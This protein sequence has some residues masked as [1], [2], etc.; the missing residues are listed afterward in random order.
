MEFIIYKK[1]MLKYIFKLEH[2]TASHISFRI[3]GI[4]INCLKTSILI[5]RK[6]IAK[7]YQSFKNA[8]D[9]P[10]ATGDL[11]LV[12][13]AYC[14]FLKQFDEI[15]HKNNIQYW[16]DFGTLIGAIR[17]KGFIP[18]DDDIDVSMPRRDYE[19]FIEKFQNG[20]EN[21]PDLKIEFE[22][23]KKNK[24]F[25]KLKDNNS[26]NLSL[27]IFPYDFYYCAL[28]KEGKKN[29][30][31]KIESIRKR[32]KK[33]NTIEEIREDFANLTKN[34]ILENKESN[35]EKPAI[36]MGID[37]PHSHK[38]KVFDWE[39]IFP[40]QKVQFEN[41]ELSAP[42][43]IESVLKGEFGDFMKIPKDS[44]PRHSGYNCIN[45]NERKILE[46]YSK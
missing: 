21:Y 10:K 35:C 22:N 2:T 25:I 44:Y 43:N 8:C 9:I 37:F 13:E 16:M 26:Q 23:N 30:S 45:E 17:H 11:R 39:D 14:G 27:D 41:I 19:K 28:D 32:N 1:N 20:F 34:L 12:Q 24:C 15:C 7:F 42:N 4:K 5:E 31:D 18:W 29:L 38:N 36:F 3:F 46:K 40:L 6:K 33:F